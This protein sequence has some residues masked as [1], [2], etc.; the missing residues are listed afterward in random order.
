MYWSQNKL[1]DIFQ[2]NIVKAHSK[3]HFTDI[4]LSSTK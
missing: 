2:R 4:D 1:G 3:R